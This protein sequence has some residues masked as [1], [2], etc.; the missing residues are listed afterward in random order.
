VGGVCR[1]DAGAEAERALVRAHAAW[2][3]PERVVAWQV[4][5]LARE[6]A[7]RGALEC[8]RWVAEGQAARAALERV[9]ERGSDAA[10]PR[11]TRVRQQEA[12]EQLHG[13]QDDDVQG[14]YARCERSCSAMVAGG[15][16]WEQ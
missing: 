15:S 4:L 5:G 10:R 8:K 13:V 3:G 9:C 2:G 12:E 16:A 6:R 7:A 1:C 11:R 14:G